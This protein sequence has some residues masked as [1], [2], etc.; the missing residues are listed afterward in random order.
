M[1]GRQDG[2]T[3]EEYRR[4]VRHGDEIEL[5]VP[6]R[7]LTLHVLDA[8]IARRLAETDLPERDP[9]LRRGYGWMHAEHVTQAN[10]GCD[11]DFAWSEPE[12]ERIPG[13]LAV[14]GAAVEDGVQHT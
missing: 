4:D 10:H 9:L 8:E 2:S 12:F 7:R 3:A 13:R 6:N 1:T 14:D 5:D 11:F